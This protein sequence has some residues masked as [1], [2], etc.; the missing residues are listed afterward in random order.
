MR[1]TTS[2]ILSIKVCSNIV[3]KFVIAEHK[4]NVEKFVTDYRFSNVTESC[5]KFH[6]NAVD[7]KNAYRICSNEKANL[8][9]INSQEEAD[10][11]V[12]LFKK[13]PFKSLKG[14]FNK[15]IIHIGFADLL[16]TGTFKTINGEFF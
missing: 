5:Y 8:A 16:S 6:S 7:W 10:V 12:K 1:E 14:S 4:R 2:A 13:Y 11:L 9:V 3:N 15:N